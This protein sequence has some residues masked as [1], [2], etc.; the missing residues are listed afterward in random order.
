MQGIGFGGNEEAQKPNKEQRGT[1]GIS[2]REP[3]PR[4]PESGLVKEVV[5]F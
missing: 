1:L 4:H 2:I 3:P 5:M